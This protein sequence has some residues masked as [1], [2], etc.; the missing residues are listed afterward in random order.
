MPRSESYHES[1][2]R[3]FWAG[4]VQYVM[5]RRPAETASY[6]GDAGWLVYSTLP[7]KLPLAR[8]RARNA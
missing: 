7:L 4:N 5:E 6:E 3:P 2:T 1:E 8:G